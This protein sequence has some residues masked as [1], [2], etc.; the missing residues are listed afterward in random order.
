MRPVVLLPEADVL[1]ASNGSFW[2]NA[3]FRYA[4][5]FGRYRGHRGHR[6]NR[7]DQAQFMMSTRPTSVDRLSASLAQELGECAD[8]LLHILLHIRQPAYSMSDFELDRS[9]PQMLCTNGAP[10]VLP[11]LC[12][13]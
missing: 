11:K 7:Y 1:N 6:A 5:E 12:Y 8:I 10:V 3:T 2:H 4:A 13:G 9:M